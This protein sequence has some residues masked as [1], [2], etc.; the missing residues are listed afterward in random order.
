MLA[1]SRSF[2]T[3]SGA[4]EPRSGHTSIKRLACQRCSASSLVGQIFD[5]TAHLSMYIHTYICA[6]VLLSS[7]IFG[8]YKLITG[9]IYELTSGPNFVN[10]S[11]F[12]IFGGIYKN[13]K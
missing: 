12:Y 4:L 11:Q 13:Y 5:S 8:L 1:D 7:H 9:P 6:V 3:R 2:L 10:L